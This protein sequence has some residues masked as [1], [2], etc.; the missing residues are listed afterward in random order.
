MD[1]IV[2]VDCKITIFGNIHLQE[3]RITAPVAPG[4]YKA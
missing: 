2:I 4:W 3:N 1:D